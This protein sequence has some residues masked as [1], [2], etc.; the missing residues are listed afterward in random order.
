MTEPSLWRVVGEGRRNAIGHP[1]SYQLMPGITMPPVTGEDD[2]ARKRAGF[3]SHAL[4]MTPH[5]AAER[6][7]A[8][9]YPTRSP[10]GMGLPE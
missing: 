7:A 10:A 3:T 8:G 2:Y 6:Y 4:W 1:T 9:D 5:R